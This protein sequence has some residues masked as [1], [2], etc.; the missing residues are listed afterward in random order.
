MDRNFARALSLVLKHEGGWADNPKDPG[1]ATMRGVTLATFRRYVKP[2]ATKD[3]L[4][5][6]TDQQI[7]A[8]YR[9]HYWDAVAGA[10]LPDGIDYA[11]FDFAVNSGPARAAKYL[12]AIVGVT[13]DG[14][15]GPAT[16]A[17]TRAKLHADVIHKLCDSR[18]AFLKRLPIWPTFGKG[19]ASR[20]S[21]V[22]RQALEL[23]ARP[24]PER[25][26][27]I[28]KEVAKPVVPVSVD[29]EVKRQTNGAGWFTSILTG[30]AAGAGAIFGADWM[31][32]LAIGGV[33]LVSLVL[34][35][36]FRHRLLAAINEVRAGWA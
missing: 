25:P 16:L 10:E 4:R 1:G 15:I 27:I 31:T 20:V 32:V 18:I 28:E 34:L 13:T 12:Q 33:G 6:I 24:T 29:Q 17:A 35:F 23:A 19:W 26:S 3:D 22:R 11:V 21:D 2:N 9:R 36:L 30:G 7:A 5:K 14:K 8:V